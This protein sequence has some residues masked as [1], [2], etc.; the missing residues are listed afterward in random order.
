VFVSNNVSFKMMKIYFNMFVKTFFIQALWNYERLQNI[1]FLFILKPLLCKVYSDET[2]KREAFL[3]HIG[4][5]NTHPY[6]ASLIIAIVANMEKELS[7]SKYLGKI[8]DVNTVKNIMEGPLAAMGDSFFGGTLRYLIV[9]V[10]I[11]VLFLFAN[12]F[13]NK[14]NKFVAYN[15][16]IP[17][18]FIFFYNIVHIPVRFLLMFIGFRFDRKKNIF[19]LSNFRF[20]FLGKVLYC[21]ELVV[22]IGALVLYLRFLFFGC[23][24]INARFFESSVCDILI[25]A[26]LFAFSIFV[27]WKFS[28]VFL[29]YGTVLACIGVSCF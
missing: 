19:L 6:M 2:K 27:S 17:L 21:S 23:V 26:V 13:S 12:M 9:F 25:Y 29:F 16:W 15:F 1:G 7:E 24:N 3:R 18:V 20:M 22:M 11:F 5:F 4:F 8:S 10:S 14:N 28:A